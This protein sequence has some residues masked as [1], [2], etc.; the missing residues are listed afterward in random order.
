MIDDDVQDI[1]KAVTGLVFLLFCIIMPLV[2]LLKLCSLFA[3]VLGGD[4]DTLGVS[5]TCA[6]AFWPSILS[7]TMAILVLWIGTR[8]H[9][10]LRIYWIFPSIAALLA[11]VLLIATCTLVDRYR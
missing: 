10:K 4:L 1:L 2:I 5:V 6:Y 8:R 11:D 3:G 9:M 7:V